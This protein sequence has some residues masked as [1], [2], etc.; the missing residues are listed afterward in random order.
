M[1]AYREEGRVTLLF[2]AS[3]KVELSLKTYLILENVSY[4]RATKCRHIWQNNCISY[5]ICLGKSQLFQG[6]PRLTSRFFSLL[7]GISLNSVEDKDCRCLLKTRQMHPRSTI[8]LE[9]LADFCLK[10]L[11]VFGGGGLFSVIDSRNWNGYL[12]ILISEM[13]LCPIKCPVLIINFQLSAIVTLKVLLSSLRD[14]NL[15]S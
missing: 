15:F 2:S 9:H 5:L 14:D 6:I 7:C 10:S 12:N 1:P 11:S 3:T 4:C 8:T 13:M